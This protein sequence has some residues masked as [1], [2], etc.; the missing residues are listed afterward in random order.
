MGDTCQPK[1]KGQGHVRPKSSGEQF[2]TV[3]LNTPLL[4]L[5]SFTPLDLSLPL[6]LSDLAPPLISIITS[7][8]ELSYLD[9]VAVVLAPTAEIFTPPPP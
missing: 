6:K 3:S 2:F 5:T 9:L 8:E 4:F 7:E 1:E